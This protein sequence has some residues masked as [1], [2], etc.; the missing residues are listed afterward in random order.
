VA[1][2]RESSA[3]CR[4]SAMYFSPS[5]EPQTFWHSTCDVFVFHAFALR[6]RAFAWQNNTCTAMLIPCSGPE[7]YI[8]GNKVMTQ[9]KTMRTAS[10]KVYT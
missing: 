10:R 8:P 6:R 3:T 2:N 7:S 4:T 5:S 1:R 9:I